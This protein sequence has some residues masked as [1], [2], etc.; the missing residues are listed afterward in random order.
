ML[1]ILG[2]TL[3]NAVAIA[4]SPLPI[5]AVILLLMSPRAKQVGLGYLAGWVAGIFLA[6]TA[7]T[8]L[9]GVIPEATETTG[10]QPIIG[11]IQLVLGVLLLLLG[12]RQW[13]SRP[14]PGETAELPAWMSKLDSMKVSAVAGLALALAAANPKNLLL[15]VAAGTVIGR[16]GL[17]AAGV[18][19]VIVCFTL[20]A[21]ISVTVPV[22]IAISAPTR[23]ATVLAS[24]RAWLAAH[25]AAIM[26][27][28]FVLLGTQIIGKGIGSF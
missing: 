11:V 1:D 12:V 24:L 28:V 25:N 4:I 20:I 3:P 21:A 5:I 23:A 8:L 10:S 27:V 14:A 13:K 9:A 18:A 7:A 17:D 6:T 2:S 16:G 15:A 22:V 26:T 19:V